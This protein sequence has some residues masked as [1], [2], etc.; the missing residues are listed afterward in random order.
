MKL[1][2][3]SMQSDV[4][5]LSDIDRA[6]RSVATHF[7]TD[8]IFVIGSQ[9]ALL[10][11]PESPSI[12]RGSGEIDLYPANNRDWE[13]KNDGLECSEEIFALFGQ[14]STFHNKYGFYIDGVDEHTAIMPGD[15]LNRA[16]IRIIQDFYRAIPISIIAPSDEDLVISKLMR[17]E[18][19]DK[20]FIRAMHDYVQL[21][22]NK[23]IELLHKTPAKQPLIERALNFINRLSN[24]T[25]H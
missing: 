9:A 16:N 23:I 21:D 8:K 20:V 7:E 11:Y 18:H 13:S 2:Q 25:P 5:T 17:L 10:K 1:S 14:G 4:R 6:A 19:K 15:W 24:S 3:S 12:M 22:K